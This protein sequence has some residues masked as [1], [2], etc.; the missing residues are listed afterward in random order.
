MM[1]LVIGLLVA[2]LILGI[3]VVEGATHGAGIVGVIAIIGCR[4]LFGGIYAYVHSYFY[5]QI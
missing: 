3:V 5:S 4:H 1:A 2:I